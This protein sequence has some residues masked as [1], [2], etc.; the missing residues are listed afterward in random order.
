MLK[1]KF[2]RI[3]NVILMQILEQ[4]DEIERGKRGKF[5]FKASNGVSLR[6]AT[7]PAVSY[8]MIYLRGDSKE[9]DETVSAY[10][11]I[12]NEGAKARLKAYIEAVKE[13][14]NSLQH[15]AAEDVEDIETVIAE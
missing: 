3:E 7:N 14:N 2:W 12:T 9:L 13:Y 6:S 5:E 8:D 1:I 11:C 15:P 4:G 10:D